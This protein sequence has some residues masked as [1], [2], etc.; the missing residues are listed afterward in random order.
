MA[1]NASLAAKEP[2][3]LVDA[4]QSINKDFGD[5]SIMKIDPTFKV[6]VDAISTGNMAID[7]ALGVGGVPRGRIVEIFG[8]ESS[9]KSTLCLSI[10]A[11][12]QKIGGRCA[13][14][15]VEH[16]VDVDYARSLG[17]DIESLYFS[18]PDSGE[19]ALT[20]CQRLVATG[21]FMVVVID[22][23]AALVTRQEIEGEIGDA[24]VGAQ[25]RLMSSSLRIL[26]PK[27]SSTNTCCIFTNQIREKV[28]VMWG[29][30]ETTPGGR[31]L[32]FYASVRIDIRR[33]SAIKGANDSVI[34]NRTKATIV[35]NKVAAPFKKAEFDLMFGEGVSGP[36]S[37]LD[38]AL[39]FGVIA[40]KGSWL[41]FDGELI[42]QGREAA[43]AFFKKDAE[44]MMKIEC[45]VKKAAATHTIQSTEEDDIP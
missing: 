16:A 23:V 44:F 39:Q 42:A 29:S 15:D 19:E 7:N 13:F 25:A 22:S 28:G 35:K 18:Q 20:I 36:S 11:Q 2:K 45:M 41:S 3:E 43:I 30:P 5:G 24:T 10:I 6:N 21:S 38:L 40:K 12:A 33:M 17:V 26:N 1:G 34:G 32:K 37:I 9:G 31:A 14:I 8:P 4:M 27:I